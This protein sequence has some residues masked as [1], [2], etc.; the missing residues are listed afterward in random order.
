MPY[1]FTSRG[2][3]VAVPLEPGRRLCELERLAAED[4]R[5]AGPMRGRIGRRVGLRS[6]WRNADGVWLSTVTPLAQEQL[7]E[8]VGRAA[9]PVRDDDEPPAVE[10][11]APDL[12]DG[13]VERVASGTA[14]RRRLGRSRTSRRSRRTAESRC[15]CVIEDALGL[16]RSSPTCRSRRRGPR[17]SPAGVG[18]ARAASSR[19]RSSRT[20]GRARRRRS[21]AK[22]AFRVTTTRTPESASMNATRSAGYAGS[23]GTYAPPA[24]RIPRIRPRDPASAPSASPTRTSGPTPSD[25]SRHASA[26]RPPIQLA[27]S[28]TTR[29]HTPPP[30][31]PARVAP[32]PRTAR[33]SSPQLR[34]PTRLHSSQRASARSLPTRAAA[35]VRQ[36]HPV[37]HDATK[38]GFV[39]RK[40]PANRR[41]IEEVRVVIA[42]DAAGPS[43]CRPRSPAARSSS[44]TSAWRARRWSRRRSRTAHRPCRC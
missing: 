16:A 11:R 9:D 10:Q 23:S 12:P 30:P 2:R 17:A 40:P 20:Q 5:S 19:S 33:A 21:A 43:R 26:I 35:D 28:S 31:G 4:R 15:A 39:V 34:I 18:L 24:F 14:S 27:V 32:A 7:A 37:G 13:E 41:T 1:M 22:P 25:R 29:H 3:C 36:P 42:L 8:V 44:T 38:Q 6:S